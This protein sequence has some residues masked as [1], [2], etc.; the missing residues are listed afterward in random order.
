[1]RL[2]KAFAVI[3]GGLAVC[4][5]MSAA[6]SAEASENVKRLSDD[7]TPTRYQLELDVNPRQKGFSGTVRIDVRLA[8]AMRSIALHGRNLDVRQ[9]S[10]IV[11]DGDPLPAEYSEDG[12]TGNATLEFAH[13]IGPG[14]VT[15]R[16]E[17]D[18]AFNTSYEGLYKVERDGVSYAYTQFEPLRARRMFPSFDEPRF[19]T[20]YDM[21][22]TVS[23][24]DKAVS[25]GPEKITTSLGDGRKRISFQRTKPI[26]T[27]L[28]ALAVG[29]FD[30]VEWQA[31]PPNSVRSIPVPL[32]GI[33]AKGKGAKIR[34][35]LEH[36]AAMMAILE[37]YFA[38]PYPYAKLDLIAAA[39]FNAGGM[40]NVGA[41]MYREDRILLGD[42][43]SIFQER[44]Y[45]GIHAHELAHMWFGNY[46]THAWWDDLWLNEAFATWMSSKVKHTWRPEMFNDRGPIRSA[47]WAKWTDRRATAR[48]IRN[49]IGSEEDISRAFDAVT[50]SKGGGVLSMMEQY[51]GLEV[52]RGGL[53]QYLRRHGH[54]VATTEDFFAAIAESAKNPKLT[55]AFQSFVDQPGTPLVAVEWT[56]GASGAAAVS[57]RQS[58]SLPLGST[59]Q[60]ERKWTIPL[61]LAWAE[62]STRKSQCILLEE[63]SAALQ[64]ASASC[65]SAILPNRDGAA[66]VN[67][68][69]PQRGWDELIRTLQDLPPGEA[70]AMLRSLQS[71]YEAGQVDTQTVIAASAEAA[72]SAYWDVVEAPMQNLRHM[73]LY[74][75]PK[76]RRSA[77]LKLLQDIYRP[78]IAKIDTSDA[79][80]AATPKDVDAALSRSSLLWFLANDAEEPDFE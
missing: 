47:N 5:N 43:P 80:L 62:N 14:E 70:L 36:T 19:K 64:L 7:V 10:A 6:L 73:K 8:K 57:L 46:V 51:V 75:V 31:I 41:I 74:V 71:A 69:L 11:D 15:L 50:Y 24:D 30:I 52:F 32:R 38:I 20:P 37:D 67:F 59:G 23:A 48:K 35:A 17:Y 68:E 33:T 27:Y 55:A 22:V 76:A 72:R 39:G 40:E 61:C 63:P 49:P 18:G 45:A 42:N 79:A 78:Q 16:F 34:Y 60:K 13:A 65:P 44:G 2:I 28:V 25:N 21:I 1:M 4:L 12:E 56:C 9:V 26:P 29:D 54:G 66:Y 3:V 53:R 77:V 58:R